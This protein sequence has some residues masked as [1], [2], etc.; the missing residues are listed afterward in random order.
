MLASLDF[1]REAEQRARSIELKYGIKYM[2]NYLNKFIKQQ[3]R[4]KRDTAVKSA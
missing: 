1:L 3:K 2:L 4:L